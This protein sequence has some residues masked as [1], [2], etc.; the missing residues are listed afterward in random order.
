MSLL[1]TALV[2]QGFLS[3][4]CTVV[5]M[6]SPNCQWPRRLP[7]CPLPSAVS[8]PHLFSLLQPSFTITRSRSSRILHVNSLFMKCI[9]NCLH[10]KLFYGDSCHAK[11]YKFYQIS[12]INL[13]DL[14]NLFNEFVLLAIKQIY[15]WEIV[16]C[17]IEKL[18]SKL[19]LLRNQPTSPA[20]SSRKKTCKR[21]SVIST[22]PASVCLAA[23]G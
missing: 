7:V 5:P 21:N 13:L 23:N 2:P 6:V 3:L 16:L 20:M 1:S 15:I 22:R 17:Y 14:Y 19:C 4:G 12:L 18:Y 11:F 8:F 10:F 9:A